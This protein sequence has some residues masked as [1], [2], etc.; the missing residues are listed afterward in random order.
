MYQNGAID[1]YAS[2]STIATMIATEDSH[3][4]KR[5][6]QP[7]W[8]TCARG[9]HIRIYICMRARTDR[10]RGDPSGAW[11]GLGACSLQLVCGGSA[12]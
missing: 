5:N 6:I 11:G 9:P 3:V 2:I 12:C 10:V 7:L 4:R 1:E 8:T